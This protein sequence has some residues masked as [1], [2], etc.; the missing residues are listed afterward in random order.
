MIQPPD[1]SKLKPP[2]DCSSITQAE[3]MLA[4]FS[5]NHL[6]AMLVKNDMLTKE[7]WVNYANDNFDVLVAH[8]QFWGIDVSEGWIEDSWNTPDEMTYK[9]VDPEQSKAASKYNSE[10]K[11]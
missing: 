6:R 10:S 5:N 7:A 2:V 4:L 9:I 8:R 3:D 1:Y 11:T